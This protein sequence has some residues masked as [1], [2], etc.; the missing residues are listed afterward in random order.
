MAAII[1]IVAPPKIGK[2]STTPRFGCLS[3]ERVLTRRTS[4]LL[5]EKI[6]DESAKSG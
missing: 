3:K 6:E 5:G 1:R 4:S 2:V